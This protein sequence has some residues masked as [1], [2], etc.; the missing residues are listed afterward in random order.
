MNFIGIIPARYSSTRLPGKPLCLI[1]GK[2]MIVR[3]YESAKKWDKWNSLYVA[4]DDKRI[5]DCCKKNNIPFI[6]T[7]KDHNDCLDR[8]AEAS[9]I[10]KKKGIF[11]DIYIIIQG[12]EPL[13]NVK[14]LDIEYDS[15]NINFYT[16]ITDKSEIN[17]P[18]CPKVVISKSGRALYLSRYAIPYN[19]EKTKKNK[20]IDTLFYKQIGVYAMSYKILNMYTSLS[21]RY[22]EDNEGIGINRFLDNDIDVKMKYTKYNST[23]VDTE[24]D[25]IKVEKMIKE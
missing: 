7:S 21:Y 6:M 14:S 4:T 23:S 9:R 18:N 25:R 22:L 12:D 11:A 8:C 24:D 3:T 19:N 10:L 5:A 15:E 17:D 1:K 20:N 2:E 16:E 13:F